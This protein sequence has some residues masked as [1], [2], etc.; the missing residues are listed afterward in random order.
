MHFCIE[1]T[2]YIYNTIY[3]Q[4]YNLLIKS[5]VLHIIVVPRRDEASIKK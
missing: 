3:L 5:V 4:F 1:A 2:I